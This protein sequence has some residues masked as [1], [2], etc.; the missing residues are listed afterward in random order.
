MQAD[1]PVRKA[2]T[3]AAGQID[4][5]LQPDPLGLGESRPD[6]RRVHYIHPLGLLFRVEQD[7]QTVSVLPLSRK[8]ERGQ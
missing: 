5:E 1:S 3:A 8:Q 7:E 6:G 4:Q 2:I